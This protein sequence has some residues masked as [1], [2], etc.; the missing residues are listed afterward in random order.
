MTALERSS[1]G[2]LTK[3]GGGG[4]GDVYHAP[5]ARINF[6]ASVAFKEYKPAWR[7]SVD[8]GALEAMATFLGGR[9]FDEGS[10]IVARVAWPTKVVT[11]AG[12]PV[13]F[14]MPEVADEFRI[15]VRLPSG[16]QDRPL[17]GL[18]LLL[19]SDD[20][21]ARRGIA[22]TER[23]RYL[24]LTEIAE[25]LALLHR[26]DIAVGDLSPK[27]ILFSLTPNPRCFFVDADAMRLSGRGALPQAETPDWEISTVSSE[28]LATKA[29]DRYK[30]GLLVLRLLAGDQSTRDPRSLPR[31]APA[32]IRDLVVRALDRGPTYRPAAA[33]WVAPLRA[34][35]ASA[36][37]A[38]PVL[39]AQR[40]SGPTTP[41]QPAP[42]PV[43]P[44]PGAHVQAPAPYTGPSVSRPLGSPTWS[45]TQTSPTVINRE[46]L[47]WRKLA[48]V[49]VAVVVVAI[50][51]SSLAHSSG[52]SNQSNNSGANPGANQNGDSL[53]LASVSQPALWGTSQVYSYVNIDLNYALANS[54]AWV[55][56]VG[57]SQFIDQPSQVA[58][59]SGQVAVVLILQPVEQLT[60][61]SLTCEMYSDDGSVFYSTNLPVTINWSVSSSNLP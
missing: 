30:L 48:G 53:T 42:R 17:A 26:Y 55:A 2:S 11:D 20:Y 23:D 54:S 29:T 25:S 7:R 59:G 15:S 19:N 58:Q 3:L 56:C 35:S 50:V 18:Q 32:A 36:S 4:Q 44:A 49:V 38:L 22:I 14:L 61:N 33:D 37:T 57:D 21:L 16:K 52:S 5:K 24:L 39:A 46:G 40:P 10:E 45:S 31:S 8:F 41:P 47:P 13:G 12:A 60:T 28:E 51:A 27:N 9:S 6:A 34:A 43:A 1:L